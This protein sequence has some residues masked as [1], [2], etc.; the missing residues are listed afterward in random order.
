AKAD[1]AFKR[2]TPLAES[3]PGAWLK[4]KGV[5]ITELFTFWQW[6]VFTAKSFAGVYGYMK[7]FASSWYYRIYAALFALLLVHALLSGTINKERAAVAVFALICC[8]ILVCAGLYRAW[9]FDFQAQG[10][11]LFPALSMAAFADSLRG[12]GRGRTTF[13][14]LTTAL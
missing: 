6:H 10:R 8:S 13:W 3:Y 12:E 7:Y 1:R 4:E 9:T 5:S 2:S 14:M 11:Y